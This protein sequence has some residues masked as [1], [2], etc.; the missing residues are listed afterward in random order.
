MSGL[1]DVAL[2]AIFPY[3]SVAL[4]VAGLTYSG[5]VNPFAWTARS[6]QFFERPALG[7]A[8]LTF[9]WG[10]ILLFVAH[11][12]GL[13]AGLLLNPSLVTVFYWLGLWAGAL[14]LYGSALALSRRVMV[15]EV[16]ATSRAEDYVILLLLLAIA[17]V[18]LYQ[19]LVNR[20]FGVSLSVA[21]WM[22]SVFGLQPDVK[23][24]AGLPVLNKI[25]ISLFFVL[26]A[27]WPYTKLVHVWAFPW[28]FATRPWISMRTYYAVTPAPSGAQPLPEAAEPT[29]SRRQGVITVQR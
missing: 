29:P 8:I 1:W 12:F 19:A 9:H 6:S 11:L 10:V 15:P 4:F 21:P 3:V 14:T 22:G 13:V 24:M 23:S 16:R 5:I 17:G 18:A 28:R 27:Y 26:L 7:A 2:F 20:M 25:H